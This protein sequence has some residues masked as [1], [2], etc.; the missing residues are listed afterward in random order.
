MVI[1]GVGSRKTP[2]KI[3]DSMTR[4]GDWCRRNRVPLRSGHADG[5]DWAFELGAQEFCIAYL[6]WKSFREDY[7]SNARRV[8]YRASPESEALVDRI[9]PNAGRLMPG[10]RKLHGR[11]TWQVLGSKLNMPS[12]ALVCWTPGGKSV[13]GTRTA[14]VLAQ[15]HGIPVL[16]LAVRTEP[17]VL[18]ALDQLRVA[19]DPPPVR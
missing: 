19:E 13:G 1:T 5:A 15:V 16:N 6:P 11:N 4:I 8:V 9:H 3:L 7:L 17:E 18:E 2:K 12:T 14:I 10:A